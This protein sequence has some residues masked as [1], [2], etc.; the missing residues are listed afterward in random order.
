M[1]N[2]KDTLKKLIKIKERSKEAV[3]L[4]DHISKR[5]ENDI[6][7][8]IH[9]KVK[10]HIDKVV[11]Y[12]YKEAQKN[13][14]NERNI[15]VLSEYLVLT[16]KRK[17]HFQTCAPD[18]LVVIPIIQTGAQAWARGDTKDR[19]FLYLDEFE[20]RS[21]RLLEAIKEGILDNSLS[22]APHELV[23]K[24][25]GQKGELLQILDIEPEKGSTFNKIASIIARQ[26]VKE[27]NST[28]TE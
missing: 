5:V 9:D 15:V 2:A 16:P 21:N 18:D 28:L 8:Q 13:L 27:M 19:R 4:D 23:H 14:A 25:M 17:G 26:K 22:E 7:E 20:S 6:R 1:L 10:H 11:D 12:G 3:E 24:I